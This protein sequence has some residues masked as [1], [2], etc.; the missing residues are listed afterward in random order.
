MA[1]NPELIASIINTKLRDYYNNLDDLLFDLENSK[2][3]IDILINSGY[4]YNKEINQFR[5]K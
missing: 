5:K 4:E 1:L 3:M 2:E